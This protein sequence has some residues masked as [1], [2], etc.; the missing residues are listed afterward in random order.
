MGQSRFKTVNLVKTVKTVNLARA[1]YKSRAWVRF[2]SARTA[3]A[4]VGRT[5]WSE[6]RRFMGSLPELRTACSGLQS[7]VAKKHCRDHSA[8]A[9]EPGVSL[10][11][12][13]YFPPLSRFKI[14]PLQ[15]FLGHLK[16]GCQL[17][18]ISFQRKNTDCG[19]VD[20]G[21]MNSGSGL[22]TLGS[23]LLSG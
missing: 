18:A 15:L 13:G 16:N 4:A 2:E 23:Y 21:Q 1:F 6:F 9:N 20:D 19:T 7:L 5:E 10:K 12:N 14:A 3:S 22:S 17:L 8:A 11:A